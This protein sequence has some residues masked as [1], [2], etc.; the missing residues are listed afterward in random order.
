MQQLKTQATTAAQGWSRLVHAY[1]AIAQELSA[2]LTAEHGLTINEYEVLLRLARAEGC[3]LRRVDLAGQ[4]ILSPSGI[5]RML[6]RLGVAGLVEKGECSSDA[7]VTYAVLTDRGMSKLRAAA[8]SHDAV[9]EELVGARLGER[10]LEKLS[11]I[12]ERLPGA[13]SDEECSV[14]DG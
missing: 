10:D 12:L 5:T 7:R 6:D 14:E 4:L 9:I 3:R 1:A 11:G 8:P 13:E 2:R